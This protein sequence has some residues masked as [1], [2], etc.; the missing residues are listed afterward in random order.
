MH[1]SLSYF[2]KLKFHKQNRNYQQYAKQSFSFMLLNVQ[3]YFELDIN[4]YND[5]VCAGFEPAHQYS[6][7]ELRHGAL[8]TRSL[9]HTSSLNNGEIHSQMI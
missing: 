3:L 7:D 8:T 5:Q 9:R 1:S 6:A 4:A 2:N